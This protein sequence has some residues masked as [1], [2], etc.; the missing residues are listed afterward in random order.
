MADRCGGCDHAAH[1]GAC[2]AKGPSK[3]VPLTDNEGRAIGT[4]CWAVRQAC[5]CSWR[6]CKCGASVSVAVLA[7]DPR[8]EVPIVRGSAHAAAGRLEAW[9]GAGG[10][11]LCRDLADGE[12]VREGRIRGTEHTGACQPFGP[13]DPV[14]D[15]PEDERIA[16]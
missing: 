2:R 14:P 3:C 11:L 9:L 15:D 7:T 4:S 5:P 8:V 16:L 10:Q 1:R 12:P 6:T 13:G